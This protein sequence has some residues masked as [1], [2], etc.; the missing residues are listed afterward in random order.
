MIKKLPRLVDCSL[1]FELLATRISFDS[2]SFRVFLVFEQLVRAYSIVV[3][4]T[5]IELRNSYQNCTFFHEK[6]RGPITHITKALHDES[7]SFESF[8]N[9][10]PFLSKRMVEN[11]ASSVE[12]S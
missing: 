11:L 2:V 4:D 12:Y 10:K 3:Q 9:V 5:S 1:V 8:G 7:L 6:L